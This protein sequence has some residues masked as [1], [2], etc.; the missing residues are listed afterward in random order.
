MA[1]TDETAKQQPRV[2]ERGKHEFHIGPDESPWV[3]FIENV[4]IRHLAFDVRTGT[5]VNVLRVD[6]GGVLGR[7]RHRGPVAGFVIRG[8]WRYLEHDWVATPGSWIQEFPGGIHTLVCED[9]NGME[10]VF[11]LNGPLEFLDEDENVVDT[12]DVF[13]YI[14]HYLSYCE[15]N[16]LPVNE[17]LFI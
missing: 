8:S 5:A 3:P 12:F 7:H 17:K 10:T 1:L 6:E 13:W 2:A 16:D 14:D 4:A 9:P 15:A 11:W